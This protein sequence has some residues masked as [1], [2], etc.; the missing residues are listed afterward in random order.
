MMK[1]TIPGT[2]CVWF[3]RCVSMPGLE[4]GI[5]RQALFI[6]KFPF[7]ERSWA[8]SLSP[9]PHVSL[10]C[11][12]FPACCCQFLRAIPLTP[13]LFVAKPLLQP[14]CSS[15]GGPLMCRWEAVSDAS[16]AVP[17]ANPPFK[18]RKSIPPRD[19]RVQVCS[20]LLLPLGFAF[21]WPSGL[22]W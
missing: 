3:G 6:Q 8:C 17:S 13:P 15:M 4:L 21:H 12:L 16:V 1:G 5:C 10:L 7:G 9:C 18:E 20:R 2:V 22:C 14:L 19:G 11:C